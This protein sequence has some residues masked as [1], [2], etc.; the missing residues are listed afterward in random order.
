MSLVVTLYTTGPV[1]S[2]H[3]LE[4]WLTEQGEPF[5]RD[6]DTLA[7]RA[8]PV[9]L[10]PGADTHLTLN[11]DVAVDTPLVR[12]VDLVFDLSVVAGTDVLVDGHTLSR[13]KLWLRLANHRSRLQIQEA[14][15]AADERGSLDEVLRRLWAVLDALDSDRDVRWSAEEGSIVQLTEEGECRP[16][17][18]DSHLHLLVRGWLA[19]A[20]PSLLER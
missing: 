19:E 2:V 3:A 14:L 6:G 13:A 17:P 16:E 12:L 8:L 9:R 15:A 18:P 1:P 10:E 20:Y 4:G 11:L 7:L 5:T